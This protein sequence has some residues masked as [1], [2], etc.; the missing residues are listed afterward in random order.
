M[1]R[2]E[3]TGEKSIGCAD[4]QLKLCNNKHNPYMI[5]QPN[6]STLIDEAND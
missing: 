6:Q 5:Y 2:C 3:T 4:R 1:L